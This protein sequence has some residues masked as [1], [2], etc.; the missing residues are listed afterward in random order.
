MIV[1]PESISL[2]KAEK[3][4][5]EVHA[6]AEFQLHLGASIKSLYELSEALDI[7]S[8]DSFNHHV[9]KQK[10]DFASW[11]KD[12]LGDNKLAHQVEKMKKRKDISDAVKLRIKELERV[13]YH[14]MLGDE[15]KA[16][17]REFLA[18]VIVGFIIG[19][20]VHVLVA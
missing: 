8:E 5:S 16:G 11:I 17:A 2:D 4:L 12:V 9:T 19:V 15:V 18:G 10:N 20:I 3:I 6:N 1:L 7:I 14:S 13:S